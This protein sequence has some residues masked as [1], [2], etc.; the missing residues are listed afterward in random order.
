VQ[1]VLQPRRASG[2]AAQP[3]AR[4]EH[5]RVEQQPSA[6]QATI[7]HVPRNSAASAFTQ[8]IPWLDHPL[9]HTKKQGGLEKTQHRADE[10]EPANG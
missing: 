1:A 5:D 9:G 10:Q 6:L 8:P 2:R 4:A 3:V 7:A